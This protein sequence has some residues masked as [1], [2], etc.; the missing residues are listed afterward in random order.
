MTRSKLKLI[1]VI[2]DT[3][4]LLRP[5]ALDALRGVDRI[6]HAGDIGG[7][8]IID[9]L[10]EIAPVSVVRGNNDRDAWGQ[11]LPETVDLEIDG[12]RVHV[13]H[14]LAELKS[15][16]VDSNVHAVIA[17][18]SHKPAVN[19]QDNVL[20]LNPGSAG[21]RRFSLPITLAHLT[22]GPDILRATI[23]PLA[24]PEGKTKSKK[25]RR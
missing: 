1:G 17:G 16:P 3:H 7:A 10:K 25:A 12:W 24:I 14:N 6:I 11:S 21:P 13:L 4:G 19:Q 18:H 9:E 23:I 20:L 5:E 15:N 8:H 22:V 2:S